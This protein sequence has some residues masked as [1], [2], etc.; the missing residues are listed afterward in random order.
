V[1]HCFADL[2]TQAHLDALIEISQIVSRHL[3]EEHSADERTKAL[4]GLK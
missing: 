2:L 1:K 3:V 4:A